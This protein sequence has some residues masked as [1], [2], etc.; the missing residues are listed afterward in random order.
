LHEIAKR[1]DLVVN[2]K[3]IE[4]IY[5]EEKLSLRLKKK[6]IRARHL[7]VAQSPPEAPMKTWSMDFV[8]DRCFNGRKSNALRSLISS[9]KNAQ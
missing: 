1:E 7:R 4:R 2:H 3:R 9:Q 8:H 6:N 5:K